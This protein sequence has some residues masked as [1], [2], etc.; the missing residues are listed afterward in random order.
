[1]VAVKAALTFAVICIRTAHAIRYL[2][3]PKDN[4]PPKPPEETH[5]GAKETSKDGLKNIKDLKTQHKVNGTPAAANDATTTG[6]KNT[7]VDGPASDATVSETSTKKTLFGATTAKAD[8]TFKALG[9]AGLR[10]YDAKNATT[11]GGGYW[12]S[13]ANLLPDKTVA[14]TAELRGPRVLTGVTI[15]WVYAPQFVAILAK[16]QRD[17]QFEEVAPFQAVDSGETTQSI[18]FKRKI[19]A[20]FVK[21][22]MKGQINGYFGIEFVQFHGEPN[23][24]F[25]IQ[26]GITSTEDLC[27]QVDE[28][29]E[30]VL[31]SCVAAIAS[32]KFNDIWGYNEKRQLYNPATKLCMTLENNVDTDGGR[33]VMLPCNQQ[34][35]TG[36]NSWDLL[37]NNQIKLRRPG[38]LCLSQTGSSA[39]LANVALNKI[40]SSSMTRKND[41]KCNAE[42]ALDGNLQSYW[43]SEVFTVDSI[44]EKVEFV[45]NLQEYYKVRKIEIDW[46]APAL[47]YNI[48]VKKDD[49][50]WQLIEKI[51]AN[52]LKATVD[53]MHNKVIRMI[54][55]ELLRPNPEYAN[56]A[57]QMHYGIRSFAAY[58]NRLKTIV[59][60]CERAKLSKDARDKYFLNSVYEVDLHSGEP[61]IAAERA[62]DTLVDNIGNKVAHIE[63]LH[64]KMQQCK[65][66]QINSLKRAQELE[67]SFERVSN[68]VYRFE[69]KLELGGEYIPEEH[70]P[71]D[72]I[73]IKNRGESSPS[74]FYYVYPPCASHSIR[75][76]C[77][78]YTGASY[79][80]A[81][82]ESGRIGLQEVYTT[83][84][85]YGLDPL[86]IHHPSQIDAIQVMLKTMDVAPDCLYPVAVKVGQ[87]FKSLDLKDD[88]TF[89]VNFKPNSENNIVAVAT[90]GPQYVDGRKTD[91]TGIVCSSNY[92]SIR[93][94]TEIIKLGCH[95]LINENQKLK[96]AAV[97]AAVK[98]ACPQNC[99][100]NYDEGVDVEGG[101]D[102]LYSLR[103]PICVAA[104]HAGEYSRNATLEVKKAVAPAEF[105][106]FFQNGI[107][108]TSVPALVGD[109]AFKVSRVQDECNMQKVTP[110]V[111]RDAA[112]VAKMEPKI[113]VKKPQPNKSQTPKLF[114]HSLAIDAA[115]GEAI[116]S[117]VTQVN[118][119][120]GKAAPVFLD[121]FHHH[122]SETIASAIQLIKL[123]D[124][125][126]QPIEELMDRLDDGVKMMQKKL[127]WLAARVTYKKKPLVEGIKSLKRESAINDSFEPWSSDAV[128]Q[129]NIF[130]IF[131]AFTVGD[132]QGVPKWTVSS[133]SLKGV[134]ENV[135]SQTSE[136]GA[137]GPVS[138]ALLNVSNAQ[139][140]DFVFSAAVFPGGSGTLGLV[141][142]VVDDD[143]Y[144]LFQMVQLN[145]GYKRLV[146]M[147]NGIP[148][149][150]AKI[151]DGGFV[152]GL[153]YTVRIEARQCRIAI[154]IVQ[155]LEPVFDL[156]SNSI[157]VI[158]CSHASGSVGLFS[159]Q[160]NLA[161]FARVHVETLPC[162][163]YDRPPP[164][165]KPPICSVY[166]ESFA[167]GFTA[168]WRALDNAGRWSFEDNVGGEPKVIAHRGYPAIDGSTEPSM[169][170]LK[171]GRS[172]K[173]GVFRAAMFPQC[174]PTGVMGLLVHFGDAGNYVS[175]ECSTR[176]CQ[177][178]QMHRGMRNI[179]AETEMKGLETG[180]WNYVELLFRSDSVTA[181]V[182][183]QILEAVFINT[184]VT[185]DVQLGGTVGLYSMGC[186]GCAFAEV[187]LTPNY[188]AA[189]YGATHQEGY[190]KK[191]RTAR[192]DQCLA[193]DR[194]EHCKTIAPNNVGNCETNY[195]AMC[196]E[197]Q[198]ADA[199]V[200]Q[201][202][203]YER[204]R[205]LDHAAVLLQTTSDHFWRGCAPHLEQS[206]NEQT[207]TKHTDTKDGDKVSDCELCCD[208]SRFLEGVPTS[209]NR[210]AQARC[211]LLC[212][213]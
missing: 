8:S 79:Y 24:I 17:G 119:Q 82:V 34:S 10:K 29:D 205:G 121:L 166:K 70:L 107:E 22:A 146:R 175:F 209:V 145:G 139:Y 125:Q 152:D 92:S 186:A 47:A 149:E 126:R 27:L 4:G 12:C 208:S 32:F 164:P 35:G 104:I 127:Q 124:I 184:A 170:L 64:G 138:G 62:I 77:D 2:E 154:A 67:R 69:T 75:V 50:D 95:T 196:C 183:T 206:E 177:A 200:A 3:A 203:C 37:P 194:L 51:H 136:F 86:Q 13:E 45:V 36:V 115:T 98:V 53:N 144:Y 157:D 56:S 153:W 49:K 74:G 195:C 80:V 6:D 180:V 132:V 15:T 7:N 110:L 128:T 204:C 44:P 11:K 113:T 212:S 135:I 181:S 211:R 162:L 99:L 210:A 118:Q 21:I 94:P 102:G 30:V 197:R 111:D 160:I 161:H 68:A 207:G 28:T 60:P 176:R 143:N 40:A 150:I 33:V 106:G 55:L 151:E 169:A 122:A 59:E 97:G 167:V 43:A 57:G 61:L 191:Q 5:E 91:M 116:G 23:P 1:M 199:P 137:R 46:E 117:L 25:S 85:K 72:C 63:N 213:A 83:C 148:Y 93:L 168:N 155:G 173:A 96:E 114:N 71:A 52:T 42:S 73:E 142:R 100:Q 31:E 202:T 18:E 88:V 14:W 171:G 187:T 66:K 105:E 84:R 112:K 190:R 20:Q 189:T 89:A 108:S 134:L 90:D 58:S 41:T 133:L 178:I 201:D 192:D 16:R 19:D 78:M 165:P 141:F 172:C 129:N 65:R 123:A 87:K 76:Y 147:V 198:H 185:E 131:H 109:L 159:G 9:A 140:Y 156:P 182:G 130:D 174:E 179:L 26:A 39:G 158:D 103:T 48:L 54:K 81:T 163:R 38:N 120:S 101:N 188:A 193:I